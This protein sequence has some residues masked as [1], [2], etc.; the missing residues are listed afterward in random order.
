LKRTTTSSGL[1]VANTCFAFLRTTFL[2]FPFL[3]TKFIRFIIYLIIIPVKTAIPKL[4]MYQLIHILFSLFCLCKIAES[5]NRFGSDHK[6]YAFPVIH[7]NKGEN[8]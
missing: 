2:S 4:R 5:E 8:Q 3:L 1:S 6:T 7:H